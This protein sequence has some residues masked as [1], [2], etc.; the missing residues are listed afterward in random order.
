M[1]KNRIFSWSEIST[2][3]TN[4]HISCLLQHS[5][6]CVLVQSKFLN[7]KRVQIAPIS[8]KIS[9]GVP[10]NSE[11]NQMSGSRDIET[12]APCFTVRYIQGVQFGT[13]WA[14]KAWRNI[15]LARA[16]LLESEFNLDV[17]SKSKVCLSVWQELLLTCMFVCELDEAV[18]DV[19]PSVETNHLGLHIPTGRLKQSRRIKVDCMPRQHLPTQTSNFFVCSSYAATTGW[20]G[21]QQWFWTN[22]WSI[23]LSDT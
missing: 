4:T 19:S 13:A 14:P 23:V 15:S 8:T 9:P 7:S 12:D 11:V 22:D 16:Q 2:Y 6:H 17:A 10:V 1:Y 5:D 20:P 3:N 18:W 21:Q